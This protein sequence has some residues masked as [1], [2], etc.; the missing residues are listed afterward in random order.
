MLKHIGVTD[1][2]VGMYVQELSGSCV[3]RPFWNNS[4]L[5]QN[6][7]VLE[8]ILVSGIVGAWIDPSKG[9]DVPAS[10]PDESLVQADHGGRQPA[11]ASNQSC[12]QAAGP[13]PR[14]SM[15]EELSRALKDR[16]S[17]V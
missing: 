8:K 4:F 17:V 9:A 6:E 1:L 10:A 16:K 12:A 15:S 11:C 13:H 3:E 2:C 5:I 14:V 7:E